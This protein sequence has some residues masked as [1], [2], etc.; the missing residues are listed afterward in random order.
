MNKNFS[1]LNDSFHEI[2]DKIEKLQY[3]MVY[4]LDCIKSEIHINKPSMLCE[5]I[6]IAWGIFGIIQIYKHFF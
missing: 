3:E 6:I 2:K 4:N 5:L 1:E